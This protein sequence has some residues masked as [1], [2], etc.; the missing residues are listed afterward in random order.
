M[1]TTLY[2][3]GDAALGIGAG[4][5]ARAGGAALILADIKTWR[6]GPLQLLAWDHYQDEFFIDHLRLTAIPHSTLI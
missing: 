1:R 3:G 6:G 4:D 2:A 5:F